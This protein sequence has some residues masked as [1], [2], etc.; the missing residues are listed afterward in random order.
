MTTMSTGWYLKAAPRII[1]K[2]VLRLKNEKVI[3][4]CH[5]DIYSVLWVNGPQPFKNGNPKP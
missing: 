3:P 5:L 4:K 1:Y 2:W